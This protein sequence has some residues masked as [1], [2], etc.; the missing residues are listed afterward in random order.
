MVG[1]GRGDIVCSSVHE[2]YYYH[3]IPYYVMLH[4]VYV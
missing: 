2:E 4:T 1:R 3:E